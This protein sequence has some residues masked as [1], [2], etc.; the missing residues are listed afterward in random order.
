MSS[1]LPCGIM[2]HYSESAAIGSMRVPRRAGSARGEGGESP[3]TM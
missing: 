3:V 1:F 2:N